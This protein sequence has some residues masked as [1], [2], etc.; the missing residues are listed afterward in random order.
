MPRLG[1]W[2]NG[3]STWML[4]GHHDSSPGTDQE[5]AKSQGAGVRECGIYWLILVDIG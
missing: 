4:Q 1:D 2:Q 3:R 5:K